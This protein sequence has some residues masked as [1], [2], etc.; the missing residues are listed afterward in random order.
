[1]RPE[2]RDDSHY[3][4]FLHDGRATSIEEAILRHSG[5]AAYAK[6]RFLTSSHGLKAE[7][8]LPEGHGFR[9]EYLMKLGPRAREAVLHWLETL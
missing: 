7:D 2:F 3:P 9:A 8:S 4:T 6:Y 5:E 1:V